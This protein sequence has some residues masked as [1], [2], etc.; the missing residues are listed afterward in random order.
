M[1]NGLAAGIDRL[2]A[3]IIVVPTQVASEVESNPN[4]L[5][6]TPSY[7]YIEDGPSILEKVR[8]IPGVKKAT[9][10]L[11]FQTIPATVRACCTFGNLKV[12]AYDPETDFIVKVW[13]KPFPNVT[14]NGGKMFIGSA[15]PLGTLT[16]YRFVLFGKPY[17]IRGRLDPTGIGYIDASIF[18]PLQLAWDILTQEES[19][20]IQ[21]LV[22]ITGHEFTGREISAVLVKVESAEDLGRVMMEIDRIPGVKAV[23]MPKIAS[24][25]AEMLR[26]IESFTY[27]LV[28]L[29]VG[30]CATVATVTF[31]MYAY[32]RKREIGIFRAI[33]AR[34]G[35]VLKL[36]V[37]ESLVL[38]LIGGLSGLALGFWVAKL[39]EIVLFSKIRAPLP[40]LALGPQG[41]LTV[42]ALCIA[43]SVAVGLI[44]SAYPAY[45][46]SRLAPDEAIRG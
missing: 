25:V 18:I 16:G 30:M 45:K 39:I 19:P 4:F 36:V 41:L 32:S 29:V 34:R 14:A 33:G 11:Y 13:A 42:A 44:A 10:H 37:L 2:G 24:S 21:A 43:C 15:I 28:V 23:A 40:Y 38:S 12:I 22:N 3:D 35:D 26:S 9:P 6:G 31:F 8:S 27:P 1:K 17:V 20:S 7:F 46:F 5:M